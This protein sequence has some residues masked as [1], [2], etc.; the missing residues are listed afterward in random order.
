MTRAMEDAASIGYWVRIVRG[1]FLE[2]P[3]LQLTRQQ[4]QK[5]WS[6]DEPRC[7]DVLDTL[8]RE[9]FLQ[10][11]PEGRYAARNHSRS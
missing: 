3:G 6:L 4:I 8:L 1:G 5:L 2:I 11:T 7:G 10:V 9:A